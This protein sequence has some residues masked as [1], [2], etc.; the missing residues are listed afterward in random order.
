MLAS[1]P[2]RLSCA[3]ET[4]DGESP[5]RERLLAGPRQPIEPLSAPAVGKRGAAHE[6]FP[7]EATEGPMDADAAAHPGGDPAA[8]GGAVLERAQ[9]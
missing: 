3:R 6:A 4:D 2:V 7:F 1:L 5:R 8:G 9:D